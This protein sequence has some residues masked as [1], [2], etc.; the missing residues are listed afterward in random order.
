MDEITKNAIVSSFKKLA[1][2]KDISEITVVEIT[3]GCGLKRQTFYN[4]F[5]DKYDLIKWIYQNEVITKIDNSNKNWEENFRDMFYYFLE[6][7]NM[8]FNIYNSENQHYILHFIFRQSKPLIRNFIE[9]KTKNISISNSDMDL[10]TLFYAGS[11]GAILI[12]WIEFG[13]PDI[14]DEIIEKTSIMLSGN[15]DNYIKY[16][17]NNN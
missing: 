6:N 7:K 13:M 2:E 10:L 8:V 4:H 12:N 3:N 15:I 16:K 14:V 5:R 1:A 11:L 9:E 17:K